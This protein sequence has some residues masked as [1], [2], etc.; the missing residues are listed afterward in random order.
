VDLGTDARIGGNVNAPTQIQFN[1]QT[2]SI[3]SASPTDTRK[4]LSEPKLPWF[5]LEEAFENGEPNLFS[6]L[7]WNFRLVERLYGR[8]DELNKILIWAR[9]PSKTPSARL[10][11]GE[12][13]FGK[14]RLVA[15]A[16]DILRREGW[17]AGFLDSTS[18]LEQE[19]V[20]P[21]GL[22]LAVDYPE[23][24]PERTAALLKDS[25]N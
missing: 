23:E 18:D 12:G 19:N 3:H 1:A 2:V 5:A 9:Q 4:V 7:R 16:A 22:F 6:L 17:S 13:G 10:I 14:T 8:E 25:R 24:Q 21:C 15:T 20:G 11:T